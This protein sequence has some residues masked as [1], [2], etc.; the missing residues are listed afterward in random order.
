M[1]RVSVLAADQRLSRYGRRPTPRPA[2]ATTNG[3][4]SLA[5]DLEDA[6]ERKARRM[7]PSRG[8]QRKSVAR[9]V[10]DYVK[11]LCF[12]G[13]LRAGDR[14][15]QEDLAAAL[16]VSN[17]PVR[18][19]LIVLEHEGL[20][21]LE[22]HRGAF[23][24]GFA[25]ENIR[26]QYELYALLWGWAIRH[27]VERAGAEVDAQLARIGRDIARTT[28]HIEMYDVMTE[29]ADV[30]EVV[31]GSKDW[32]RLFNRLPRIVP[33]PDVYRLVPGSLEA[34][35]EWVPLTVQAIIARDTTEAIRCGDAMNHAHGES[36]IAELA[37]RGVLTDQPQDPAAPA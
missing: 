18:E 25:S 17:T 13:A 19:A 32:R 10:V 34:A 8:I 23:V 9:Q 29:L 33:G 7:L 15:Q 3:D 16:G 37:R 6:G 12:E 14:V 1:G 11:E 2:G 24:V 26:L 4:R 35:G 22:M 28:D 21:S 36:M 20:V 5:E 31:S 30:F 27:V